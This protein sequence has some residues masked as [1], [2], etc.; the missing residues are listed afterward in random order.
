MSDAY[1]VGQ[2][3]YMLSPETDRIVPIQVCEEVRRRTL[4]EPDAVNY[5]IRTGP[6]GDIFKLSEVKGKLF[7]TF[8][9]AVQHLKDRFALW[10][11]EQVEWTTESQAAWF[12]K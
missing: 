6:N 8:E 3:I 2:V 12:G 7:L 9:E 11:T 5:L 1:E 4:A 10:L